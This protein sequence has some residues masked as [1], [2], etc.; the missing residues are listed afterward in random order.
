MASHLHDNHFGTY[1]TVTA[2]KLEPPGKLKLSQTLEIR[3]N[4]QKGGSPKVNTS[5][6]K[7]NVLKTTPGAY[8]AHGVPEFTHLCPLHHG[9]EWSNEGWLTALPLPGSSQR[10]LL[11]WVPPRNR[12]LAGEQYD[13]YER[14]HQ[15]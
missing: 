6:W 8:D 7:Q 11:L 9:A 5:K 3:V 14:P 10:R 1:A 13:Y 4:K 2:I 12:P 15:N